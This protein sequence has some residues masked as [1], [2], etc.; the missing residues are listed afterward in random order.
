M[1]M[2]SESGLIAWRRFLFR[3]RILQT[4]ERAGSHEHS[5]GKLW[6]GVTL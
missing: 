2:E 1:T 3:M 5:K 6:D 4:C